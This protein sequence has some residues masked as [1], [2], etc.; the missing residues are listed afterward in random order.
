M[1]PKPWY[2]SKTILFAIVYAVIAWGPAVLA[3]TGYGEWT[4]PAALVEWV[5]LLLPV[6]VAALRKVTTRPIA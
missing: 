1:N 6:I 5:N 3:V 2:E 4:P